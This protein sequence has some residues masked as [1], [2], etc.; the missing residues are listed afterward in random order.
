M[1]SAK[2]NMIAGAVLSVLLLTMGLG[3]LSSFIFDPGTPD[4]PGYEIVVAD[5]GPGD[6]QDTIEEPTVEP[7]AVRLAGASPA[8]GE[9]LLRACAA[10]HDFEKGGPHK[11]G[12]E[13][14]G[15]VGRKPGG[16]EGF[17]YSNAMV[18][19]GEANGEWT[20]EGLDSFLASPSGYIDGTSMSYR[21]MRKPEDRANMIA[22]LRSLADDP[23]PLPDVPAP[24]VAEPESVVAPV[25]EEADAPASE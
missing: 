10:C 4:R 25:T 6:P 18:A 15:I 19:Y 7:I 24:E 11:V 5:T 13:L 1:N 22:Y 8:D 17:R 23:L 16:A 21:G 20:Y 2:L 9:S 3:M 14:W 12:P